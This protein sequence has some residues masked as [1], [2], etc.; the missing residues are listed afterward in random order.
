VILGA[1]VLAAAPVFCLHVVGAPLLQTQTQSGKA[2]QS[3][4]A[5]NKSAPTKSKSKKRTTRR[6]RTRGQQA[7]SADRIKEIQQALAREGHYEGTPTGKWDSMS[8]SA[9]KSFQQANGLNA[10]GK[11]DARTLQKLGLGSEVAGVAP[12]RATPANGNEPPAQP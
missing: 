11:L 10:T 6:R 2:S 12:P 3:T 5:A 7:P 9:L 8:T 1:A 4:A